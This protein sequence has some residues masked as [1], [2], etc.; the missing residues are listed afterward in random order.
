MTENS[1]ERLVEALDRLPNGFPRTPSR[2]EIR[3]LQKIF[4]SEE[5]A[6]ASQLSGSMEPAAEIAARIGLPTA[7]IS[8]RL[9]AMVRRG[10]VWFDKQDRT[11]LFRLA[12]FIVGI[13]EGQ[14]DRL[15][16]ELAHLVEAYMLEG[17]AAG[18]MG[19]QPALHRVLPAHKAMKTESVLPYDDV[20]ALLLGAKTYHVRDCI[21]RAQQDYVG[22]RCTFPLDV[23]LSFSNHERPPAPGDLTQEE[24]L[25]LLDRCEDLGL[26]HT[27]SNVMQG[28]SYICNCCGCCCGILR[29]I[30]E[31]GIEH[32]VARAS[33]VAVI[34]PSEC[35]G[36]GICVQRCQVHA[37]T[38]Q[39]DVA[40][41]DG[42]RCIGCGLCVTGC[43][44]EAA[45][46]ERLP[47]T[48]SIQPPSDYAAWE[49]ERLQHRGLGAR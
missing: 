9:M 18:I 33:Y 14:L 7:E 13:Y 31:W 41:V 25:A 46:L 43:P 22:R 16:H 44:H 34:A 2:V 17:G 20:R 40:V 24:A 38:L 39:D 12:P 45:R 11:L 21:C 15:D 27:V 49:R 30:T 6:L 4:T 23:C 8:K 5:A 10:L 48:E 36:C 29:G 42:A 3:L 1:Y 47:E 35:Q 19:P 32:S 28:M 26:V 37:I